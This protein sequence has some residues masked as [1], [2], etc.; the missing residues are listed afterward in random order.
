MIIS[1][2]HNKV[3]SHKTNMTKNERSFFRL[4]SRFMN[5]RTTSTKLQTKRE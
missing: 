1:G 4:L 3:E 5:N 2:N